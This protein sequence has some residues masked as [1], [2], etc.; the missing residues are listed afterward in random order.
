MEMARSDDDL[1]DWP[2]ISG[3]A[4]CLSGRVNAGLYLN[5]F[6]AMGNSG[7]DYSYVFE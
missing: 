5:A 3:I 6:S 4:Y 1:H 7:S 2:C